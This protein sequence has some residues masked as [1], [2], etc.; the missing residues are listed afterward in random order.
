MH[1]PWLVSGQ[2]RQLETQGRHY[3][4]ILL[5]YPVRQREQILGVRQFKQKLGQLTLQT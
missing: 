4:F 3:P 5:E 1:C 2:I